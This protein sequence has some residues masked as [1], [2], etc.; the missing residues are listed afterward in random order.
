[1]VGLITGCLLV[2]IAVGFA[3]STVLVNRRVGSD[4]ANQVLQDSQFT[5]SPP[6]ISTEGGVSNLTALPADNNPNKRRFILYYD[7]NSFYILQV[8]GDK[9]S[10]SSISFERLD[11]QD[12]PSNRFSGQQWAKYYASMK[13]GV[14]MRIEIIDRSPYLRPPE[15]K[16][17][18]TP[19]VPP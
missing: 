9:T 10:V 3:L 16:I 15:C 12:M 14:C 1:V 11:K 2:F 7:A 13:P 19:R 18:T 17:N 8:T 4:Q 6:A 5:S